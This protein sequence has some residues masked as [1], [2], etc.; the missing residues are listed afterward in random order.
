MFCRAGRQGSH[1]RRYFGSVSEVGDGGM[2]I[3]VKSDF[4]LYSDG[5][6]IVFIPFHAGPPLEASGRMVEIT[7]EIVWADPSNS[8]LGLKYL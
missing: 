1:H 6:L 2:R 8:S 7:G 3:Q 5:K 4:E